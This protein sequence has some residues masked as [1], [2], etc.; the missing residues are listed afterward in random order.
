MSKL[1]Q[2]LY[3]K[4]P[5]ICKNSSDCTVSQSLL[6][7]LKILNSKEFSKAC[8]YEVLGVDRKAEKKEIDRAYKK[9]A[10]KWHPEKNKDIVTS[11]KFKEIQEAY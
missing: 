9:S 10:L 3:R 11:E 2:V 6:H 5:E 1:Q 7:Q 8:Y 4:Y